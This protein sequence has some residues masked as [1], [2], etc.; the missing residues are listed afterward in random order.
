M[1]VWCCS[2]DLLLVFKLGEALIS[3]TALRLN[4]FNSSSYRPNPIVRV[5]VEPGREIDVLQNSHFNMDLRSTIRV[6]LYVSFGPLC[7]QFS[8]SFP[9]YFDFCP[10]LL[11]FIL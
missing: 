9:S 5:T 8:L 2:E 1:I 7:F 3:S 6:E 10:V 4:C 11:V